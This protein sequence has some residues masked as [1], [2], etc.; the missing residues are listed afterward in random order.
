[1]RGI[2]LILALAPAALISASLIAYLAYTRIHDMEQGLRARGEDIVASL[3]PAAEFSVFAGD[4]AALERLAR[5]VLR[6]AD[7]RQVTILDGE[8]T[9]LMDRRA[10]P[11]RPAVE[12][13]LWFEAPIP[14]ALIEVDDLRAAPA[15][16]EAGASPPLG[17]VRV[18]LSRAPTDRRQR[19]VVWIGVSALLVS[20]MVVT[21]LGLYVGGRIYRPIRRISQAFEALRRGDLAV[22][23]PERSPWE[24][25]VLE[26][27]LNL[28]ATALDRTQHELQ[29]RVD[30]ATRESRGALRR[31]AIQNAELERAHRAALQANEAQSRFLS[32]MSHEI[33]TPLHGVIASAD[34]LL[35]TR[36]LSR[37]QVDHA[38]TIQHSA[39]WL[40]NL[41]NNLLDWSKIEAT[42]D[43][44]LGEA[45][46]NLPALLQ[47]IV[48]MA[49]A[50]VPARRVRLASCIE[51]DVPRAVRGDPTRLAQIVMN[52]VGNAV[53]FTERGSVTV[54]ARVAGRPDASDGGDAGVVRLEVADTGIGIAPEALD[55]I[56]E[57]FVQVAAPVARA[58]GGTGLGLAIAKRL[59]ERMGGRIGVRSAPGAG[60][61]FWFELPFRR[62]T[63]SAARRK[64]AARATHR[65]AAARPA[66][67]LVAE[68]NRMN[69]QVVRSL[70]REAGHRLHL[71]ADGRAA[72]DALRGPT[73]FDLAIVDLH[74]P[75][76][77][78][79]EVVAR[80]RQDP[81]R[82]SIPI[83]LLTA[84]ATAAA[85]TVGIA[86]HLTKPILV[87]ALLDTVGRL[88]HRPAAAEGC[89]D[90]LEAERAPTA[91]P[92]RARCVL[93][94]DLLDRMGRMRSPAVVPTIVRT[95]IHGAERDLER[96]RQAAAAADWEA[97]E[98]A[99]HLLKGAAATLGADRLADR[100]AAIGHAAARRDPEALAEGL[101]GLP[102]ALAEVVERLT[103]YGLQD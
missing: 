8:R 97:L 31:L 52:L 72:L 77:H 41:V 42:G 51:P 16:P 34:L 20:L 92:A 21:G 45:D 57:G 24:L 38:T 30:T 32:S 101:R 70:L 14:R 22:R 60:S 2:V 36:P 80:Y 26:R 54:S 5:A 89:A 69:R 88:V 17:V 82:R 85:Q 62:A 29:E 15:A 98:D 48:G 55:R 53:K 9:V 68:D 59:V 86:A 25:G 37:R 93:R 43:L 23:L 49:A 44:P 67:I 10:E 64:T 90:R 66:R 12:R 3:A 74:M 94:P 13:V 91:R 84:D 35:R 81:A 11:P 33:R 4:R 28:A 95:F 99:V 50:A 1:M 46:F 47:Q 71:V 63:E 19:E 79:D 73:D 7:V 18:A 102:G 56:F 100:C 76:L 27:G 83:I 87:D 39:R 58:Y 6:G 103:P 65:A 40:L 75:K 96:L 78:G 61:C